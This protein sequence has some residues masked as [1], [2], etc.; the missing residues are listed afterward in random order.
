MPNKVAVIT[1]A[2]CGIGAA[3]ATELLSRGLTVYG[4][5]RRGTTPPGVHPISA[6]VTDTAAV[7]EAVAAIL[8]DAGRIDIAV[9]AAGSGIAGALEHIP[10]DAA[11][12]QV[13]VNLLGVDNCLRA[14]TPALRESRGRVLAI[15]SVAGVFPIPFQAHYSAT[16]AAVESLVRAYGNETRPFGI[17]AAVAMLGDTSTGFTAARR[18]FCEGDDC[19]GGRISQS[20]ARMAHDEEHGARPE[21]VARVLARRL[22]ARRLPHRFTVGFSYRMLVLLD[23]LL[24]TG[25]V[26]RILFHLYG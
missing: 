23:R 3:L 9:L 19:Y 18:T 8:R 26:D 1:G 13:S 5:S 11:A 24:P 20:V 7:S 16:K 15:G 12:R 14:L 17:R 21:R 10:E 6:D 4:I 25:L 2:S 22:L